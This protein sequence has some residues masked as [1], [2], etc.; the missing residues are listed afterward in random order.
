MSKK[1]KVKLAVPM[2]EADLGGPAKAAGE[3]VE[4]DA[5]VAER[6]LEAG[7]IAPLEQTAP[8]APAEKPPAVPRRGAS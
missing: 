6:W 1:V 4:V 7:L 2:S 5:D 8:D 3:E